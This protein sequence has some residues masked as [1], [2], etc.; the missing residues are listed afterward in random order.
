MKLLKFSATWCGPCKMQAQKLK[1]HPIDVEVEEINVDSDNELISKFNIRSIPTM[2]LIDNEGNS[3]HRWTGITEPEEINR[4]IS[5]FRST[6][7]A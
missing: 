7:S 6:K 4:L 3:L 5:D 2:I 1:E